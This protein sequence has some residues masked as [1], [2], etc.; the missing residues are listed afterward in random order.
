MQVETCGAFYA[1][2]Y[3]SEFQDYIIA[4]DPYEVTSARTPFELTTAKSIIKVEK[5]DE[6]TKKPISGVTFQLKTEM[7]K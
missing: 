3:N 6:D 2:A 4:A 1:E 7:E 5:T